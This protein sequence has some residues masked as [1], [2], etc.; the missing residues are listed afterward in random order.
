MGWDGRCW[1]KA[2]AALDISDGLLA[3]CGHIALASGVRLQ[4]ERERLPISKALLAFLGLEDARQAALTGGDDYVLA[5]TLPPSE[6]DS[7]V[8]AGWPVSVVGRVVEGQ[9]VSLIDEQGR[10]ITPLTRGYQHF[11]ETR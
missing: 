3:D 2:S 9:G 1:G 6:L 4:V 7:L 8:S 11:R 5:F 10:D